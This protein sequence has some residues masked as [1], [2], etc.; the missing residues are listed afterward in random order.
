VKSHERASTEGSSW[1]RRVGAA[2]SRA[3][4]RS[5]ADVWVLLQ[6]TAA[7]TAAWFIAKHIA[8]HPDPFFAP[9]SAF[10]A[11]NASRG[12]R[13]LN[14]VRLLLGVIVGIVVGE[15]TVAFFAEGYG[16]LAVGVFVATAIAR[17]LSD[18]RIIVAQAATASILTVA[19]ARGEA[20]PQRLQDALI[21]AGVA[22]VFSQF[23][24]S[25][26]PVR[27]V[28]RA[29][30]SA[31]SGMAGGLELTAR[32]LERSD[33]DLA[34]YA[35]TTFRGLHDRLTELERTREAGPRVVRHSLFWRYRMPPVVRENENAAYLELLGIS[36][37]T[38]TRTAIL[39]D[40]SDRATIT[41]TL[42]D[43]AHI[44]AGLSK[45]PADRSLRQTA[46]DEAREID[47]HL[48]AGDASARAELTA[49]RMVARMVVA[50][51]MTFAGVDS[52]EN[53]EAA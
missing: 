12:E 11:L 10:V 4:H 49:V 45:N 27:L 18:V 31:L 8:S 43:L 44:L 28:R 1:W 34:Q 24:F 6:G 39:I 2:G 5:I 46:V 21:G 40:P 29:E 38:L 47:L 30:Q 17:A 15:L 52:E 50:D 26:E 25:P 51:I 53:I 13:G 41:P 14:A 22:L 48:T 37:L 42:R 36:C 35:M 33:S 32:A 7:A 20:G 16:S 19:V 23:L 9:M 3:F